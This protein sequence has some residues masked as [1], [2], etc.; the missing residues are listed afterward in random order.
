M[1]AL[2]V[3]IGIALEHHAHACEGIKYA[4]TILLDID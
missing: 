4:Q 1:W 2:Y 3:P